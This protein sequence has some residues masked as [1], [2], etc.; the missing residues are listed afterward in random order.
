MAINSEFGSGIN[1]LANAGKT[2]DQSLTMTSERWNDAVS[3]DM[4]TPHSVLAPYAF[5]GSQSAN[6]TAGQN[7]VPGFGIIGTGN[8]ESSSTFGSNE[9]LR[10]IGGDDDA[11]LGDD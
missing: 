4:L 1:H 7:Y 8:G 2:N 3:N 6:G 9:Q 10:F 11:P 5:S